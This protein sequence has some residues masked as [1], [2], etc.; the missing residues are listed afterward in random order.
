M[1]NR[2]MPLEYSD[3]VQ[4]SG[5]DLEKRAICFRASLRHRLDGRPFRRLAE[6]PGDQLGVD[7]FPG[8]MS[9]PMVVHRVAWVVCRARFRHEGVGIGCCSEDSRTAGLPVVEN[10]DR[11]RLPVANRRHAVPPWRGCGPSLRRAAPRG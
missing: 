10:L 2:D 3:K 6:R 1:N 11:Q 8:R 7:H 4:L 9:Q 5:L